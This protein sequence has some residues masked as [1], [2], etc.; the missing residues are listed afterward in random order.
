MGNTKMSFAADGVRQIFAVGHLAAHLERHAE[1]EDFY[2][3]SA[4][5]RLRSI[6]LRS[7]P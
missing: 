2:S 7:A 1:E 6:I 5:K 4:G 3:F